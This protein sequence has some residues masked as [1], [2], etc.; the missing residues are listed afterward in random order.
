MPT[1]EPE[2]S[3]RPVVHP[4]QAFFK[5]APQMM[6][7]RAEYQT[8]EENSRVVAARYGLIAKMHPRALCARDPNNL[9]LAAKPLISRLQRNRS[10]VAK[11]ALP[12][13]Q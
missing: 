10:A 5:A 6:R 8:S 1:L 3:Y 2:L 4:W 7:I 13:R 9:I 11:A 12:N